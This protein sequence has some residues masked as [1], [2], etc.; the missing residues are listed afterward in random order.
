VQILA[1]PGEGAL[2]SANAGADL[3]LMQAAALLDREPAAAARAALEILAADPG[4]TAAAL[5]LGTASRRCGDSPAALA[6][7]AAL[8][9]E[10]PRSAVIQ[11]EL[12]RAYVA[13]G[14]L[15]EAAAALERALRLQPALAEAWRELSQLQAAL[16]DELQCDVSYARFESLVS[17]DAHLA[18][19]GAALGTGR[20]DAATA[21][22]QQQLAGN[23][24]DAAALRLCA[25]VASAREDY[26]EAERLLGECLR[27]E[28]G[29]SRARFDLA[30]VLYR[31]Q[32][33]APILPL[34]ER[35]LA[36]QPGEF[37]YRALEAGARSLL[38]QSERAL[39]IL[40]DLL[41]QSPGNE[42]AWLYYG[43]VQR[44]A[45]RSGEAIEAYRR[46]AALRPDLGE[47]YFSLANLKTFRFSAAELEAMHA[48]LARPELP[49]AE[50]LQFEFALGKALEDAGQFA[51]SFEHYARGNTLRRAALSY[52]PGES[53][54]LVRRNRAIYTPAF[55]AARDGWGC[56]SPEPIFIVGLPRS[57]S[58]LIEQILASHSQVEATREL[59]D[60]TGFALELG[61]RNE[62][63]TAPSY[64]EAVVQL[65]GAQVAAFAARYLAQTRPHRPLGRPHF[66]DK[67]PT[68]FTH[69]GFI[70]LMFPRSRIVD[71]RR[72][73][74]PCCFANFK[75]HFQQGAWFSYSLTELG[76]FYRDYIELMTHFDAVL[77]G[78]VHRVSYEN[79]VTD[80]PGEV[81]R[82]LA[83]CGL[84][85]EPQCLRFHETLR[86]VQS[87][88]SEQVRQPLYADALDQWRNYEPWLGPLKQ[89]LG[90][91]A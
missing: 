17:V 53:T 20:L 83:Y 47:A 61:S 48:Q 62:P 58:T 63:G 23:P 82:L 68:N 36:L 5:L 26:W 15:A 78:R 11:L 6:A 33:P 88:S 74:L 28:P 14:K 69:V 2:S 90:D 87:A 75:Q 73:P 19:A 42:Q 66:V 46:S 16:G 72:A 77:P 3:K 85:F 59:P 54:A 10:Q 41:A 50:R 39:A 44:A 51:E 91:L 49:A 76:R 89:A 84:P 24:G 52:D 37:R 56:A 38:G 79:L 43:D 80:L 21:L 65:T 29:F 71:A 40:A 70:H 4:Y 45:G 9:T 7:L 55:F 8:A 64:P 34:V 27:L 13:Q 60:V 57:G 1:R 86:V 35:L 81:Q 22:L 32:K 12:G 25:Q 67:M 31:Q 18:A 30:R